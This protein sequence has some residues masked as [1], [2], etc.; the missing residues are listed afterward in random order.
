MIKEVIVKHYTCDMCG[1]T[2]KE[3]NII[4]YQFHVL[5]DD[6][7]MTVNHVEL[8]ERCQSKV[9]H[10]INEVINDENTSKQN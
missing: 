3:E 10:V 5:S 7:E 1:K 2:D 6:N 8:C 9:Y 4:S